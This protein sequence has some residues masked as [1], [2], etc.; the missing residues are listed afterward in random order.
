MLKAPQGAVLCNCAWLHGG[1]ILA[2]VPLQRIGDDVP[3]DATIA[4]ELL[5][6]CCSQTQ[7]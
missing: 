3:A 7:A 4:P 2:S 6:N 1:S 5:A